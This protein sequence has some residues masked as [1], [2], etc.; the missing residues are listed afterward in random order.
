MWGRRYVYCF[1]K[2]GTLLLILEVMFQ[3]QSD[4]IGRIL[5]LFTIG[6]YFKLDKWPHFGQL[7]STIKFMHKSWQEMGWAT[8]WAI[9]FPNSSG[10]PPLN[11]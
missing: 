2:S 11:D 10:H 6:S 4:Q 1:W 7:Y 9:F 5:W 3:A 8:F